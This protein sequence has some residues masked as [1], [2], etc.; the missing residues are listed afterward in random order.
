MSQR[1]ETE[2][3]RLNE[4]R[5]LLILILTPLYT[6]HTDTLGARTLFP[7]STFRILHARHVGRIVNPR[8]LGWGKPLML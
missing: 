1:D 5:L 7:H 2:A 6:V 3:R 4:V 8:T